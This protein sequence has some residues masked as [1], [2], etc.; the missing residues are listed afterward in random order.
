M[1]VACDHDQHLVGF[2]NLPEFLQQSLHACTVSIAVCLCGAQ[3]DVYCVKCMHIDYL[4]SDYGGYAASA[5]NQQGC[6]A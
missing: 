4:L 3:L 6:M 1:N 5:Q 2:I